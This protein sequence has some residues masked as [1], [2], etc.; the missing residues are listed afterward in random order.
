MSHEDIRKIEEATRNQADDVLWHNIRCNRLT[1]SNFYYICASVSHEAKVNLTH[2]ILNPVTI[3]S[4]YVQHGKD[5]EPKA[6]ALYASTGV[7]VKKC[8]MFL[9]QSYPFLGASPDGL[10][11]DDTVLEV[12]CPYNQRNMTISDETVPFLIRDEFGEVRLRDKH[13]YYYQIQGQMCVTS[14]LLVYTFK[15]YHIIDVPRNDQFIAEMI[16]DLQ[17]FYDNYF[18]PVLLEKY[19]FKNYGQCFFK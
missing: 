3:S 17:Q 14:S 9:S 1:S 16:C 10:I 12:K 19:L 5:C 4:K 13:Q 2:R 8:G 11:G 7:D 18:K 15:D 6:I